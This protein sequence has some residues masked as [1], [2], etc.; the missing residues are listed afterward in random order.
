MLAGGVAHDFNNLLMSVLGYAELM[1][2]DLVDATDRDAHQSQQSALQN[3]SEIRTAAL[4]ASEL[5]TSLLAYA[6]QH[7]ICLLYTSPSPRDRTRSR[8]PSSA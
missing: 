3:I 2:A 1:E 7:L 4:R 5:C 8:M 6:G